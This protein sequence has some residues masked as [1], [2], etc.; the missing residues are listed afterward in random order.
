MS[1][2][3]LI[4]LGATPAVIVVFVMGIGFAMYMIVR[5]RAKDRQISLLFQEIKDLRY[6]LSQTDKLAYGIGIAIQKEG[7]V[8]LFKQSANGAGDHALNRDV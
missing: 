3:F 4:A 5:D 1:I 8:K 6:K 2:D 7:K